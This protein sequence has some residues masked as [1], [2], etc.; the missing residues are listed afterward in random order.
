MPGTFDRPQIC[1]TF[2]YTLY[3]DQSDN[4]SQCVFSFY[5]S[6]LGR[7]VAYLSIKNMT[8]DMNLY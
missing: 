6:R 8:P 5:A 3:I 4:S 1:K 2:R 7:L